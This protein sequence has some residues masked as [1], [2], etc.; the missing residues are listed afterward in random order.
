MSISTT[1]SINI[2]YSLIFNQ[3][4]PSRVESLITFQNTFSITSLHQTDSLFDIHYSLPAWRSQA[5]IFVILT[6]IQNPQMTI[7]YNKCPSAQLLQ[8]V[9]LCSLIFNLYLPS[10]VESWIIIQNTFSITSLH[11]NMFVIRYLLFP[12]Y[13][14][15]SGSDIRYSLFKLWSKIPKWPFSITNVHQHN[16]FNLYSSVL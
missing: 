14:T 8:S 5:G 6:M 3:Y 12:A 9:L 13:V 10:R 16:F 7:F 1:S 4:L 15:Q 11:Q 2:L